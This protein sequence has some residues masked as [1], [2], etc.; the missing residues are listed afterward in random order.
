MN[1]RTRWIF[2]LAIL[3]G[4]GLVFAGAAVLS[5]SYQPQGSVVS[6]PF[7]LPDFSLTD[8][9]GRPFHLSDHRGKY[10]LIFF[11]YT[12]CPDV[13]P[14]TLADVQYI[15]GEL[16][17][18]AA[19]VQFIFITVDPERDSPEIIR[20]YLAGF[21]PAF[22]GLTGSETALANVYRIFGMTVQKQPGAGVAG[23]LVDHAT[24]VNVIDSEGRLIET[25]P[26]GMSRAA[27][28]SDLLYLLDR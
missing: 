2:L 15:F 5:G 20:N 24:R 14:A 13:C 25:F 26:F 27:M 3:T 18:H 17:A 11:G 1:R 9:A 8:Q 16:E 22:L 28:Y 4:V 6:P 23:Y 10:L 21:N 12:H 7:P 19:Q